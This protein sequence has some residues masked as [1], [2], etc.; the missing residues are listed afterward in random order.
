MCLV[1]IAVI[2]FAI[3]WLASFAML[4]RSASEFDAAVR[5]GRFHG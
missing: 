2:A 4:W 5:E 3:A 1:F